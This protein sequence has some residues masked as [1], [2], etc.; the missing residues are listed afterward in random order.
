MTPELSSLAGCKREHLVSECGLRHSR[1]AIARY[2]IPECDANGDLD[3]SIGASVLD[4][5]RLC[6]WL[7]AL[8]RFL[9]VDAGLALSLC[10]DAEWAG[11]G[12]CHVCTAG[13]LSRRAATTGRESYDCANG[14]DSWFHVDVIANTNGEIKW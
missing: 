8:A 11:I 14:G 7:A 3:L 10:F 9:W 6:S 12:Y 5:N 13:K 2:D 1:G 4:V